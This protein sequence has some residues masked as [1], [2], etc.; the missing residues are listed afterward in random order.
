MREELTAGPRLVV[1]TD[2]DGCLLDERTYS[3]EPALEALGALRRSRVPLVPATSKTR[4]EVEA[5]ARETGIDGPWIVENGGAIVLPRSWPGALPAGSL[6]DDS[7]IVVPLG[8]PREALV[9]ALGEIAREAGTIVRGFASLPRETV[10]ALTGLAGGAV[11]RALARE[12]DEP[13]IAAE[14]GAVPRPVDAATAR[15]LRVTRGGRFCHLTGETDKGRAVARLLEILAA[16]GE[17]LTS[18][19]LGDSPNDLGMLQIVDRP[20]VVPRPDGAPDAVLAGRL[21]KAELAPWPGP[22]GWNAAVLAVIGGSRLPL[23]SGAEEARN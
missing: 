18:V 4:R 8:V 17:S 11:D 21:P 5:L 20:I 13:F 12:Y 14:P 23:L 19:A 9:V 22:R 2:L 3:F 15:G 10:A 16:G 1:F 6:Q 7:S